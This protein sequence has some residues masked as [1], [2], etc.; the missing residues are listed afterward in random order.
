MSRLKLLNNRLG[1]LGN[2]S[3]LG[4]SPLSAPER[5]AFIMHRITGLIMIGFI[6]AHVF[7]T[8]SLAR[9]G[10][11]AWQV[12]VQHLSGVNPISIAFFIAMGAVIF[13]SLNGIRLLI[14]EALGRWIG[15]P[16]KPKPP[17]IAPSLK[18]FQRTSI[19]IVFAL[20]LIAW[21]AVGYVMFLW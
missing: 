16:E 20:W 9:G 14:I 4:A 8:S 21:A 7:S 11:E 5:I 13:H 10:W 15:R 17:Y 12:D 3:L 18:G 1:P 2:L 6:A 19:Y